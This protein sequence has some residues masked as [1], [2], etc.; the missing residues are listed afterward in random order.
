MSVRQQF[1]DHHIQG[2]DYVATYPFK[3]VEIQILHLSMAEEAR[4]ANPVVCDMWLFTDHHYT[5]FASPLVQLQQLL[6]VQESQF[7][8]VWWDERTPAYMK[9]IPTMPSP[10]TT[11]FFLRPA[12]I[13]NVI[14]LTTRKKQQITRRIEA[15]QP[16]EMQPIP[17]SRAREAPWSRKRSEESRTVQPGSYTG[18][19]GSG[20][21][22]AQLHA[23]NKDGDGGR[24]AF[25][26]WLLFDPQR[27]SQLVAD[28]RFSSSWLSATHRGRATRRSRDKS[29]TL[30]SETSI[31]GLSKPAAVVPQTGGEWGI[32][33]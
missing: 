6:A 25:P 10:T 5:V 20:L 7:V 9:L 14:Q 27:S 32:S 26:P 23:Y 8:W 22:L 31:S 4:K 30:S 15:W 19:T 21:P 29:T 1:R 13:L 2:C 12:V 3:G 17:L 28:K 33:V 24:S 11:I 18:N 16:E